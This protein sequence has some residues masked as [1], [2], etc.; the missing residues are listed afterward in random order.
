MSL[1]SYS[2]HDVVISLAGLYQ[3]DGYVEGTFINIKKDVQPFV[4]YRTADG[5]LCRTQTSDN[6]YTVEVSLSQGSPSNDILTKL[7]II[8]QATGFGQFPIF[9]KDG[10]GSSL[11]FTSSAFITSVPDISFSSDIETRTWSFQ[12]ENGFM[13]VG[14]NDNQ[15]GFIEDAVNLLISSSPFLGNIIR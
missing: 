4:P 15:S 14:G 9:I 10:S 8:D 1:W 13:N 7:L 2:P 12:C 5:Q 3:L 6:S 11:F